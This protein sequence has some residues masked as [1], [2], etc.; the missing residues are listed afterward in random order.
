M[1]HKLESTLLN[2]ACEQEC[3]NHVWKKASDQ[4]LRICLY[5][6]TVYSF[7]WFYTSLWRPI[8][9]FSDSWFYPFLISILK[10][11]WL[12]PF[13]KI[14]YQAVWIPCRVLKLKASSPRI[15]NHNPN[16]ILIRLQLSQEW[17]ILVLY[18]IKKK[19]KRMKD[20]RNMHHKISNI[21]IQINNKSTLIR[22]LQI[23]WSKFTK[24]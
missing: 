12:V 4:V 21:C 6:Q 24:S 19:V 18:W 5:I 22:K 8:Y 11:N 1:E 17:I 7:Y 2:R 14:I 9:W 3:S 23:V 13:F 10:Y 15:V 16:L 20:N